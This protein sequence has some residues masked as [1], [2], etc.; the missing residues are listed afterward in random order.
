MSAASKSQR[1]P[2]C[3]NPDQVTNALSP[4]GKVTFR[5]ESFS[6]KPTGHKRTS[7][8][9]ISGK[10]DEHAM[11]GISWTCHA[12]NL[13][14]RIIELMKPLV[15]EARR[16]AGLDDD[17]AKKLWIARK[18]WSN[19]K[20]PKGTIVENYLRTTR[21]IEIDEIPTTIRHLPPQK[22]YPHT[23]LTAFALPVEK[24]GK[25]IKPSAEQIVGVHSTY[26]KRQADGRVVNA[27]HQG[28]KKRTLGSS[29]GKPLALAAL[30]NATEL[31]ITEGIEDALSVTSWHGI[32]AIAGGTAG[33][34][35]HLA[36]VIP[37]SVRTVHIDEDD[38]KAGR[39]NVAK[40]A[41][42]LHARSIE[43]IIHRWRLEDVED[44]NKAQRLMGTEAAGLAWIEN[45]KP[46]D[47]RIDASNE[48]KNG[49]S[50][51]A[52]APQGQ[53]SVQAGEDKDS[54]AWRN[55]IDELDDDDI[56][57]GPQLRR[58]SDFE[59]RIAIA[60][61]EKHKNEL[62]YCQ[63]WGTWMRWNGS[64]WERERKQLAFHYARLC[65][66]EANLFAN[67]QQ[68]LK[69]SVAKSSTAK[70]VETFAQRDPLM[71]TASDDWDK[72]LFLLATP[73]GTVDLKTGELRAA[74]PKD[75]ITKCTA[76]GPKEMPTPL[77]DKFLQDVTG[78]D[79]ELVA[80][81]QCLIGHCLTGSVE[82]HIF[83][84]FY[85]TGGN[86]KGVL[87]NHLVWLLGSYAKTAPMDVFTA[88]KH[89]RHPTELAELAGARLVTA[90]E[91]QVSRSWNET[92]IKAVTGGD[93]ITARFMAKDFFTYQPAFKPLV[94]GNNK[95]KIQKVDDAMR[96]RLVLIP[97]MHKPAEVDRELT[98][99]LKAEARGILQWAIDGCVRWREEGLHPPK[100]VLDATGEYFEA[101]DQ[102][103]VWLDERCELGPTKADPTEVLFA[104][105]KKFAEA[106]NLLPGTTATLG[107]LLVAVPG[108][109]KVKKVPGD[110]R[111]GYKGVAVIRTKVEDPYDR[112]N[113][114]PFG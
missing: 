77:W 66:R 106:N 29:M 9:E 107:E 53:S 38:N 103:A 70:G 68:K 100:V 60:F 46:F 40:L 45:G 5:G 83:V 91:T 52:D 37:A 13:D 49:W 15:A 10:L 23:M 47:P 27:Q 55:N 108:I 95:P 17:Q 12:E 21:G 76:A 42:L 81:L 50:P 102:F 18:L 74:D 8:D 43:V 62:R 1:Q 35:P 36:A 78:N 2:V 97:F 34:I 99:K 110:G 48:P 7:P 61:V 86:G 26:L 30:D 11:F 25:L 82:E 14:D 71:S 88:S 92:R 67:G 20:D 24:D 33:R 69:S 57:D 4:L 93:P 105:W 85:G 39:D 98:E 75:M 22:G 64:H 114:R 19:S 65:A 31:A 54:N 87:L 59:D 112:N 94:A 3:L 84:F 32:P 90:Q 79:D 89:D 111:R 101:Q 73:D 104:S 109:E 41:E 51:K 72:D 44:S 113:D 58:G 80:F 28:A 56:T 16:P 96:R 6:I 63:Q